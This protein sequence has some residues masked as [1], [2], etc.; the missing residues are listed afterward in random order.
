MK[1]MMKNSNGSLTGHC[2][3]Q[4]F[5]ADALGT[6]TLVLPGYGAVAKVVLG[7]TSFVGGFL[8]ISLVLLVYELDIDKKLSLEKDEQLDR[9]KRKVIEQHVQIISECLKARQIILSS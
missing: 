8:N 4:E 2:F 3:L 1:R 6:F 5:L 9:L 7:K